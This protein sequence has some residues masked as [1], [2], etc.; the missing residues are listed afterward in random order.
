MQFESDL[1]RRVLRQL[2]A[3]ARIVSLQEQPLTIPY[4]LDGVPHDYT[5]DV[6]AQI[7]DGRAFVMEIKPPAHLGEF[8]GAIK[9]ASL[10]RELVVGMVSDGPVKDN[11]YSALVSVVGYEQLSIIAT[12]ELLDWRADRRCVKHSDGPD[13]NEAARFWTLVDRCQRETAIRGD[14]Q[15]RGARLEP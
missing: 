3:D 5:P 9:W 14:V 12:D 11:E 6:I 4:E 13:R 2:D 15:T 1:E 8:V 7:D 10:A